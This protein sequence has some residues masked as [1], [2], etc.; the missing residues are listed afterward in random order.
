M[1]IVLIT[2]AVTLR[3]KM[4][5]GLL[6]LALVNMMSLGSSL[7][8]LIT[9]WTA[10]ET[11]LGAVTRIR[12]FVEQTPSEVLGEENEVPD[13]QWPA[14]GALEFWNVSA[15]YRFSAPSHCSY[16]QADIS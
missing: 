3:D 6:G 1:A 2:L 5:A 14:S 11:S 10:L 13:G 9:Q 7:A 4:H 12:D 16:L 15:S 8:S